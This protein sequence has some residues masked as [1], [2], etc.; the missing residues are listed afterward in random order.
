MSYVFNLGLWGDHNCLSCRDHIL[1][2]PANCQSVPPQLQEKWLRFSGRGDK[3][4]LC[5]EARVFSSA[6]TGIWPE[7]ILNI[8]WKRVVALF[9]ITFQVEINIFYY[10]P[11]TYA[12]NQHYSLCT[13][14]VCT[15]CWCHALGGDIKTGCESSFNVTLFQKDGGLTCQ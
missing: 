3:C 8:E 7:C 6:I 15:V 12:I 2:V 13:D 14:G 11:D 4:A 1:G 10:S 5:V 9:I